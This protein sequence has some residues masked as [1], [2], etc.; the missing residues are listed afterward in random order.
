MGLLDTKVNLIQVP[1][2]AVESNVYK[3]Y[4]HRAIDLDY[5]FANGGAN[6]LR[7]MQRHNQAA[8]DAID[9]DIQDTASKPCVFHHLAAKGCDEGERCR[10][11]HEPISIGHKERLRAL[12]NG[13]SAPASHEAKSVPSATIACF[14]IDGS[15][16]ELHSGEQYSAVP[17]VVDASSSW[18]GQASRDQIA[19]PELRPSR[20]DQWSPVVRRC[21]DL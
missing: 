19:P 5:L 10:Y 17:R 8:A 3:A 16:T 21:Q 6:A 9:A 12:L 20:V 2:F 7:N 14:R 1:G 11:S 18:Q 4:A 13:A 15:R